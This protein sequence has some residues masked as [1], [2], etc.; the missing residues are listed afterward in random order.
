MVVVFIV[1]ASRVFAVTLV[2]SVVFSSLVIIPVVSF[3][4]PLMCLL[5]S[6]WARR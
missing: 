5:S 1:A 4:F 2:S 6:L 3:S